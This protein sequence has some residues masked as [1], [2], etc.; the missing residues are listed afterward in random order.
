MVFKKIGSIS[1]TRDKVLKD[2]LGFFKNITKIVKNSNRPIIIFPQA[3]RVLPSER[4]PFK[5]GAGRIYQELNIYCQPIAINSGFVW[6]K[7]G[8]K[9]QTRRL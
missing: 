4:P 6:P 8:E 9:N 7:K 5:K 1:I 3:T 2:N